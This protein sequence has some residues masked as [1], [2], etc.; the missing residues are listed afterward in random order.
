MRLTTSALILA[1]GL[2]LA[3]AA[4]ND[5]L[6]LAGRSNLLIGIGLTGERSSIASGGQSS[7]TTKG[8]AASFSFNHWVRPEIGVVISASLLSANTSAGFSSSGATANAIF[9][10]L[11]G[12]SYSPRALALSRSIRPFVSAAA[13][14]YIHAVAGANPAGVENYTETALG[15]RLGAGANWFVARHFTVLVE[16]NYHA[17]GNFERQDA[18]TRD[19]SGF[20]MNLGFGFA[21]GGTRGGPE[22]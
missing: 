2:P 14:P 15:S 20:G 9:P 21:W 18:V 16:A 5:T 12:L 6:S 4:Q 22:H 7:V 8:E 13:G 3:A 19:P 1:I 10:L 17:V 11:F